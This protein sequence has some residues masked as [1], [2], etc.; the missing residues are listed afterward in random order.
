MKIIQAIQSIPFL[1]LCT[2]SHIYKTQDILI[3]SITFVH[4][5]IIVVVA[6]NQFSEEILKIRDIIIFQI[7]NAI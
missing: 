3:P 1:G 6:V 7:E 2:A 5:R 4:S